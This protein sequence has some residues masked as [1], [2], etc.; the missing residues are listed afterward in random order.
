MAREFTRSSIIEWTKR[1]LGYPTLDVELTDDQL[2]DCVDN[3]LD[4][5]APWVVQR[6]YITVPVEECID[7]SSYNISYV[8]AVHKADSSQIDSIREDQALDVFSPSTY[9]RVSGSSYNRSIDELSGSITS[10]MTSSHMMSQL[11]ARVQDQ[12]IGLFKDN[13]SWKYIKP[14]LYL[15]VGYPTATQVTVEYSPE[16]DDID[17][18]TDRF[19]QVITRKFTLAYARLLLSDVRGKYTVSGSPVELDASTQQEKAN[20]DIEYFREQLRDTVNTQ[21]ITD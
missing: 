17:V 9:L 18:I 2:E 7:L 5:V 21:F 12:T 19:Y 8:I 16:I 4:E 10:S 20:A 14:K 1:Q 3:A 15:D 6:Q 13:I 11:E